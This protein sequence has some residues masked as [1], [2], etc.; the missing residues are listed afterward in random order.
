[1]SAGL[2]AAK[3]IVDS[4]NYQQGEISLKDGLAK[5]N[6]PAEFRYLGPKDTDTVLTAIWGNPPGRESTL[7]MLVPAATGLLESNSW[8]V[9]ITYDE[10]GYV[11]DD[12]AA[13]IKYDELLKDMQTATREANKLRQKEG[14]GTVELVGWAAQPRYDKEAH[15]LYWAKELK[16]DGG[17]E[18]TLNYGIRVLGR[19]GVLVLNAVSG[20]GQ[21]A[22]IEKATPSILSMVEFQEGHRYAD[23]NP[24]TDKIASYGLA[25]L[26]AGG[27]LT[28]GGFL[29]ML[30]GAVLA[31]KKFAIIGVI[32]VG[33]GLK[34]L[35]SKILGRKQEDTPLR[36]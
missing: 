15:K 4:L 3:K 7:G 32:A 26:V 36:G 25:A 5:I 21:L 22:E 35:F 17:D 6:V 11:K 14:Y 18:N 23:F 20:M 16:F 30:L 13:S 27:V 24:A 19:R 28:K 1:M 29:K 2:A 10:D 12:E 31:F 8:G 9:I 33:M 34:A